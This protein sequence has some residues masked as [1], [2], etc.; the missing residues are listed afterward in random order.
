MRRILAVLAA[1][2]IAGCAGSP[3]RTPH[4][5]PTG[6]PSPGGEP[7][8][9]R[10]STSFVPAVDVEGDRAVL[11]LVLPDGARLTLRYP[12][13]LA[14]ETMGLQPDVDLVWDGRWIGAIVFSYGGPERRVLTGEGPE[15]HTSPGGTEVE[16]WAARPGDGRH[17]NT[18]RWLVHRLP[19]WTVHIPLDDDVPVDEALRVVVPTQTD[20]GFPVINVDP[21][22]EL[23]EGF[24]EAGGPQAAFGDGDPRPDFVDPAILIQ[25]AAVDCSE[26]PPTEARDAYG[27]ACLANGRVFMNVQAF[28]TRR[29]DPAFVARV[30]EEIK[31]TDLQPKS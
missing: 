17:Q 22:A 23:P 21:P 1:L 6:S 29:A 30:V 16:E 7:T 11:P 28:D 14:L 5:G 24:G 8:P 4:A 31:A 25:I 26:G 18:I 20:G 9:A 3:G 2:V 15:I 10:A 19:S 27:S 12:R 13:D